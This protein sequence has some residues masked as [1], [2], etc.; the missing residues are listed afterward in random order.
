[1]RLAYV[2]VG[3][4]G[5]LMG[6]FDYLSSHIAIYVV[7]DP[8]S[9]I[10]TKIDGIDS[11]SSLTYT[12]EQPTVEH[13]YSLQTP[14]NVPST[15]ENIGAPVTRQA[16]DDHTTSSLS[17]SAAVVPANILTQDATFNQ[18][19]QVGFQM[20]ITQQASTTAS[21]QGARGQSADYTEGQLAGFQAAIR[22]SVHEQSSLN[23]DQSLAS[24]YGQN[25]QFNA[26]A[27]AGFEAGASQSLSLSRSI[28]FNQKDS[29]VSLPG[30]HLIK[31]SRAGQN[32]QFQA[33]QRVGI[34][35]GYKAVQSGGLVQSGLE[36]SLRA[37]VSSGVTTSA[38]QRSGL[39]IESGSSLQT[40]YNLSSGHRIQARSQHQANA[41]NI[42]VSQVKRGGRAKTNRKTRGASQQANIEEN[43]QFFAGR[44]MGV[45]AAIRNPG[46]SPSA[47]YN[48]HQ[49]YDY[50]VQ[51]GFQAT[52]SQPSSPSTVRETL[53]TSPKHHSH[54][55][56]HSHA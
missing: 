46:Q 9:P 47:F 35:A 15:K 44:A 14:H 22:Q 45:K 21:N 40:G 49:H 26:G 48:S 54:V 20:G 29:A 38:R 34:E 56:V 37:G 11:A 18:G 33:G 27:R 53:K 42:Q 52:V 10:A 32:A 25:P 7:A 16:N 24:I 50:G 31:A 51:S 23:I 6:M 13:S 43:A 1:M 12:D 2:A 8:S 30:D 28:Q 41:D 4:A 19:I 55:K 17:Y 36:S 5:I 39:G 3:T